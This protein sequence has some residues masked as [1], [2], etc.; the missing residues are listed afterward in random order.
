MANLELLGVE[1]FF[2]RRTHQHQSLPVKKAR[3]GC[4]KACFL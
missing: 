3:I 1:R 2:L 4:L